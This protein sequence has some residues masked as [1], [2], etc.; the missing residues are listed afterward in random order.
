MIL[1]KLLL[2][3]AAFSGM[4]V[5]APKTHKIVFIAGKPSHPTMMH[6]YNAGCLLL[7]KC[8]D[9]VKGIEAVVYTNGWPSDPHALDGADA[10]MLFMDGGDGH[11]GVQPAHLAQLGELMKKGVGL[12][13]VHYAVEVPAGKGG[14]EWQDWIGGYYETAFS[15]NPMWEPNYE[16]FPKHAV[17]RGVKPFT[18]KDE[19]YM[20][21][22]FRPNMEGV[23]PLLVAKPSDKVRGGPYVYPQ[24]PY[25]HIVVS[26]GRD[27]VM[28]WCT[29]RADGGRGFGFTGAHFHLNWGNES[30]RKIVL[31]ALVW[32]AHGTVPKNGIESTVTPEDLYA[33]LDE[34]PNRPI[35]P[36]SKSPK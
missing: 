13:C 35:G 4:N 26:S 14:K 25:A 36:P 34:K 5:S 6:E 12:G 19:W 8:L 2:S 21:M 22:R 17:T 11:G 1:P 30:Y 28:M 15:C 18:I 20:N 9:K 33:N 3:I 10:V 23:T 27:E 32:I 16:T 29:E 24:G 7:K 31:N